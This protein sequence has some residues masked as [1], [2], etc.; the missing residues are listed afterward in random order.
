MGKVILVIAM[1]LGAV[2]LG[3]LLFIW[4]VNSLAELGGSDFYIGHSVWSY[5]VSVVFLTIIKFN[6]SND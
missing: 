5:F 1:I 2:I 4:S 6:V 3:P